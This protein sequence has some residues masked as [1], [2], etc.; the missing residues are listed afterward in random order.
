MI[1]SGDGVLEF[2]AV[3]EVVSIAA[4]RS[5]IKTMAIYIT[6]AVNHGFILKKLTSGFGDVEF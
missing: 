1:T 6:L 3:V 5:Q 2:I 4:E